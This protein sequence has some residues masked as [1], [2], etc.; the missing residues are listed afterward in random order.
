MRFRYTAYDAAR[1]GRRERFQELERIFNILLLKTGGEVDTA[2]DWVQR[3]GDEHGWF[4][5]NYGFAD[6]KHDLLDRGRVAFVQGGG[7]Q[8]TGQGELRLRREALERI[9]GAL[10]AGQ[11]EGDH[12]TRSDGGSGEDLGELRAFEYGDA[13]ERIAWTESLV[14]AL[15]RRQPGTSGLELREDDLTVRECERHTG[16]ATVLLI[17]VSHSMVLYGEDRMMPAREVA[18]ALLEL[19]TTRYRKDTLDLVLFGDRAE[20]VPLPKIP[21]IQAGPYHTNTKAGLRLAQEI[22]RNRRHVN[23]QIFMITDGKPSA[24]DRDGQIYKNPFGL[25]EEIVHRTLDEAMACRR[26]GITVTTFMVAKDPVLVGFV[27][28]FTKLNHGRAYYTGTGK[29]GQ[30]LFVDYLRNRRS[31]I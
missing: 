1:H 10:A 28:E 21:Y 22:L 20:R 12:R 15:A 6:F 19:V 7:L 13:L 26:A 18:L 17:D 27:E 9:F 24:I 16:C 5:E 23:K 14:P 29:L 2:L 3:L 11:A 31:L 4:D 8:L 25:D 30:T